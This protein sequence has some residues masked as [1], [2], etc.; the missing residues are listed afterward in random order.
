ML[1][2][3]PDGR[4]ETLDG[5]QQAEISLFDQVLE[6]QSLADVAPCDID[7]E[8]E[9][10]PH[11]PVARHLVA[12]AIRWASSFSSSAVSRAISLISRR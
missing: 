2:R 3:V 4:V 9:V 5:P 1:N 11:H 10:G 7:D 6:R 12:S 8:P